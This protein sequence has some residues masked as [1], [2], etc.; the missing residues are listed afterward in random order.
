MQ[1]RFAEER[2]KYA[3]FAREQNYPTLLSEAYE[4]YSSV[5]TFTPGML[6]QWKSSMRNRPLPVYGAPVVVIG[7]LSEPQWVDVDG[8]P[9]TEPRDI[10]I[11]LLD[12][13]GDFAV[14]TFN[15][16]RLTTWSE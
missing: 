7:Y 14:Y 3:E 4:S 15:S 13:D 6:V 2:E 5:E 16:A 10:Q 12:G 9:L 1:G 8:D 11:G